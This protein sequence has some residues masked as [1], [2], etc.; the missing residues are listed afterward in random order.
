MQR[1]KNDAAIAATSHL[2]IFITGENGTGKTL[3]AKCVHNASG[4]LGDFIAINCAAIPLELMESEF[5]GYVDGAF[6]GARRGGKPGKLELAHNGTLF[7]DEIGDM[8]LSLQSKLLNVL[9]DQ[10]FERLGDTKKRK[11]NAISMLWTPF[12]N[13]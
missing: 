4:R 10:E 2:P 9:Q 12:D 3:L 5:F 1:V 7:L 6:T 8:P 13:R 11:V